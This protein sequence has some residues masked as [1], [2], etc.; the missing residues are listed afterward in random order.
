MRTVTSIWSLSAVI[1][2]MLSETRCWHYAIGT[3]LW[4]PILSRVWRLSIVA[5][6]V[7]NS[8]VAELLIRSPLRLADK[9]VLVLRR[10]SA[11]SETL[12]RGSDR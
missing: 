7:S 2:L 5:V 12:T 8:V 3:A 11:S 10:V 6:C 4:T 1:P 9:L